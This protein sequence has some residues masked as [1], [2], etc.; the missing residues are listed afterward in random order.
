MPVCCGVVVGGVYVCLCFAR[1]YPD[2]SGV[3]LEIANRR[4]QQQKQK[5]E[6]LVL[7]G[8]RIRKREGDIVPSGSGRPSLP[9]TVAQ[10]RWNEKL[11]REVTVERAT[12]N[13]VIRPSG[14]AVPYPLA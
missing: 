10:Q 4:R 13:A 5:T 12:G 9:T 2:W 3:Q 1:I 6:N 11:T 8:R 14:L 7:S